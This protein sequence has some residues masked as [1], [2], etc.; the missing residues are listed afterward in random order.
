MAHFAKLDE[1]NVVLETLVVSNRDIFDEDGNESEQKGIDFLQ[2][3]T[4][5]SN[6]KQTSFNT[7]NGRYYLPDG[8]LAPEEQQNKAFRGNYAV[9]GSTYDPN[10]D[11][12]FPPKLEHETVWIKDT[13]NF[14]WKAPVECPDPT[15]YAWDI[16]NRQWILCETE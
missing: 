1:N 7:K 14:C 10:L 4:G 6:W 2:S 13:V 11:V 16:E 12:F 8:T 15:R 9:V 3:L 5:H